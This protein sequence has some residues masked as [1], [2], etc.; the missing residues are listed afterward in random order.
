MRIQRTGT[1]SLRQKDR[2]RH[3]DP[4]LRP[5]LKRRDRRGTDEDQRLCSGRHGGGR[6][7]GILLRRKRVGVLPRPVALARNTLFIAKAAQIERTLP[8]IGR[9]SGQYI[10]PWRQ[11][12]ADA[13]VRNVRTDVLVPFGLC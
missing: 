1:R 7:G 10:L 4:G 13:L 5:R 3:R 9:G 2:W 6:E 8:C 11:V 12:G